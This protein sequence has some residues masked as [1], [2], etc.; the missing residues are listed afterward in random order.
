MQGQPHQSLKF[1]KR[2]VITL[3]SVAGS[4]LLT[5]LFEP[6]LGDKATFLPFTLAVIIS[7]WYGGLLFGVGSTVLSFLLADYFF[8]PP[9][10]AYWPIQPHGFALLALFIVVGFSISLLQSTLAEA[11][12]A[13]KK[14]REQVELAAEAGRIG[15]TES[16]GQDEVFWSPE[17]EKLF[18][19]KPGAFEGTLDDWVK[20]VHP[21]DREKF[22]KE[23]WSQ[24]ERRV[25]EL[26]FEYRAIFPDGHIRWLEGRRRLIFSESGELQ[27]IVSANIDITDRHNLENALT[28]RTEEL[29][30]SNQ[31]LERFAYTVAHDL[32]SP[33]RAV[34]TL[35]Q[36]FLKRT[37]SELDTESKSLLD[38]VVSSADRMRHLI[39]DMLELARVSH[40]PAKHEEVDCAAVAKLAAENASAGAAEAV[41]IIGTLPTVQ[42]DEGQVLRL[43]QNL[44]GNALKFRAERKPEIHIDA[45]PDGE[46]WIFSVRDNGIGIDPAYHESIFKEFHR[47]HGFAQYAGSGIGLSVCRQ[48]VQRHHGRIWVESTPGE[49]ATFRFTMPRF[50]SDGTV[51]RRPEQAETGTARNRAAAG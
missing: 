22:Q 37:G 15:F 39:Q 8:I 47:L 29:K 28:E 45:S 14:S 21:E 4:F 46:E 12:E 51:R 26:K 2:S 9:I 38:L 34:E 17:M 32:Q 11:N 41:I 48:I 44:I 30:T 50:T 5:L 35:T 1:W 43:F 33:L 25:P 42:G 7:S 16:L 23:K 27:R 13:L 18:G 36:L 24:V 31:E 6:L 40:G 10:H 19:L 20:R 3:S 49:G